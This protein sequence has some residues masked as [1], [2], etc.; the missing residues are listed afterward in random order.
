M[1]ERALRKLNT[2]LDDERACLMAGNYETLAQLAE[3]KE[4]LIEGLDI[5]SLPREKMQKIATKMTRNH[6]LTGSALRGFKAAQADIERRNAARTKLETYGPRGQSQTIET[7][8]PR[9]IRRA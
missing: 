7:V 1:T 6:E 3:N 5:D 8:L 2:L 9:T 4:K